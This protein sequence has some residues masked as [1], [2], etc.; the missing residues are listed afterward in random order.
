MFCLI[1]N[2][3]YDEFAGRTGVSSGVGAFE[4]EATLL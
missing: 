1:N 4:P 2:L 3:T